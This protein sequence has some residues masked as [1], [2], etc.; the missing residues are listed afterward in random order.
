MSAAHL[1][2]AG[3]AIAVHGLTWATGIAGGSSAH[4]AMY[5]GVHREPPTLPLM[6]A[7]REA[8]HQVLLPVCEPDRALSWVYWT[9]ASKFIRSRYAPVKEPVGERHSTAIMADVAGL[10]VPATA[11][12][13]SGNR[14][15]Q[16]GG[17]YDKL[18]A[19]LDANGWHLPTAAVVFDSELLPAGAITAESFDRQIPAV[20]TP[21][22]YVQL[23]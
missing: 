15:G 5:L 22:G 21:S 10:I 20:I 4:F 18:L 6:T 3:S 1:D 19:A 23:M 11:V 8:G 13:H 17:Y 2:A 12:D 7:L 14:I 16:G 9:S